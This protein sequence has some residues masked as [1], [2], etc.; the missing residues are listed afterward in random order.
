MQANRQPYKQFVLRI[1]MNRSR[2]VEIA[3]VIYEQPIERGTEKLNLPGS[4]N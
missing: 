3:K 2:G 4:P 1:K